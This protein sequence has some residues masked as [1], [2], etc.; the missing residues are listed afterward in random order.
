M[1]LVRALAVIKEALEETGFT[2]KP[3]KLLAVLDKRR[4]PHPAHLDYV[5][6]IFIQCEITGGE[7]IAAFDILKVAFFSQNAIPELSVDRIL[8]SQIDLM[9]EYLANPGKLAVVD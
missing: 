5:Y 7:P 9:F 2:V 1:V 6:K 4:H 8:R 3:I